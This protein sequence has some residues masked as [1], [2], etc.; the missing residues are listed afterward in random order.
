MG[1]DRRRRNADPADAGRAGCRA[2]A[3]AAPDLPRDRQQLAPKLTGAAQA[4]GYYFAGFRA[5]PEGFEWVR[6]IAAAQ[7]L[8]CSALELAQAPA[9]WVELALTYQAGKVWAENRRKR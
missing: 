7:V 1:P 9:A 5:L 4:V 2:P 3:R 6:L 8:N